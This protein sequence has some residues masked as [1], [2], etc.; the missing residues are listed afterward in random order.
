MTKKNRNVAAKVNGGKTF[1]NDSSEKMIISVTARNEGQK[2][3]LRSISENK[4]TFVTGVPGTGKT[5]L[6]VGWGLQEMNKGR[7]ARLILSRPVVEAGES[8]G[9]L[10]GSAEDKIA[11]YMMPMYEILMKYMSAKQL[12]DLEAE[13]KIM[14]LPIAYMR[15]VTFDSSF[16]VVDECQNASQK[17]MHLILTRLGDNSKVV[18]TGD[19]RQSDI[20]GRG[21]V[22]NGLEDAVQRL[23]DIEEVGVVNLG[24]ESCVRDP[25]VNLIDE[26]YRNPM[27]HPA[28]KKKEHRD[29]EKFE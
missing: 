4:I 25:L 14:I 8:L 15:G 18:M 22:M 26:R 19:T 16:V 9:Y 6:S 28:L 27:S 13:K 2:S 24:Y 20:I 5:H 21:V 1:S 17:Q 10:P 23:Q 12:K 7:F 29:T 11:P 3:A